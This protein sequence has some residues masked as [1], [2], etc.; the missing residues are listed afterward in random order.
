MQRQ[1]QQAHSCRSVS[2]ARSS[3]LYASKRANTSGFVLAPAE[4]QGQSQHPMQWVLLVDFPKLGYSN[5]V[6]GTQY[7]R[8]VIVTALGDTQCPHKV[9]APSWVDLFQDGQ[10]F[11][12]CIS[13]VARPSNLYNYSISFLSLLFSR[14]RLRLPSTTPVRNQL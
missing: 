5:S 9:A 2:F 3:N 6:L 4:V 10:S 14:M 8:L 13:A 11:D 12:R 7:D 1:S